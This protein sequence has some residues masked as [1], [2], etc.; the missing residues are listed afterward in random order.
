MG[1]PAEPLPTKRTMENCNVAVL[2]PASNVAERTVRIAVGEDAFVARVRMADAGPVLDIDDVDS[3]LLA[4]D[5]LRDGWREMGVPMTEP[6]VDEPWV[7]RGF[8]VT[9]TDSGIFGSRRWEMTVLIPRQLTQE[10]NWARAAGQLD[11]YHDRVFAG[12]GRDA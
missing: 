11:S 7:Y 2:S 8:R 6:V 5:L 3:G 1:L 4:A 12:T 9:R 10:F